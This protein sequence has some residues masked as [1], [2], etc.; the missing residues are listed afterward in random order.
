LLERAR[1]L[2]NGR[3]LPIAAITGHARPEDRLRALNA[4]FQD[5]VAKPVTAEKLLA[6]VTR[7]V[8]RI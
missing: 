3:K 4:G 1:A 6:I 5:F 8:A 2:E 7:L